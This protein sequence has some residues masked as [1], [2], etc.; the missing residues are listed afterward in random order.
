MG[1][2]PQNCKELDI[3]KQLRTHRQC[4]EILLIF[5]FYNS[6]IPLNRTWSSLPYCR[7]GECY[8]TCLPKWKSEIDEWLTSNG[9]SLVAQKVKHLPAMWETRV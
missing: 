5:I 3:T 9:A 1:Y 7:F 6:C 8:Y 4:V 2:S